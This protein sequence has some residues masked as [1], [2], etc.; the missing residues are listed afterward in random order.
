MDQETPKGSWSSCL[1]CF[2][3]GLVV[4][5]LVV[6]GVRTMLERSRLKAERIQNE[7]LR[8]WV[9]ALRQDPGLAWQTLTTESYRKAHPQAAWLSHY[10]G[11]RQSWGAPGDVRIY[12]AMGAHEIGPGRSFERVVSYWKWERGPEFYLTFEVIDIPSQGYRVDAIRL[13]GLEDYIV[14]KE[15]PDGPW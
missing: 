14:P 10:Q 5:G 1:G 9:Q 11:L 4:L 6:F 12:T 7:F 15:V 3:G 2:L 13:G 8:P